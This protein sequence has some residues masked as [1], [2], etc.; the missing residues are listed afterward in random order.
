MRTQLIY[1]IGA[2][3]LM[4]LVAYAGGLGKLLPL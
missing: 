2:A 4:L 3:M 1:I